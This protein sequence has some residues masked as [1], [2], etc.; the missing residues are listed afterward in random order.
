MLILIRRTYEAVMT[1]DNIEVSCLGPVSRSSQS[2]RLGV[3][4]PKDVRI[5]RE[6]VLR[7]E[8]T[9]GGDEPHGERY[10]RTK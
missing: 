5:L 2:V 7:R 9:E 8:E 1:G 4:A 10:D 6:E 3:I